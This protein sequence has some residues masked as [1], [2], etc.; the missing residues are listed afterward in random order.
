ML[1]ESIY[2]TAA[3]T[4]SV[5][6]SV[7]Y[8]LMLSYVMFQSYSLNKLTGATAQQQTDSAAIMSYVQ[9]DFATYAGAAAFSGAI[10]AGNMANWKAAVEAAKAKAQSGSEEA[11]AEAESG[12]ELIA[13]LIAF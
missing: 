9:N 4:L 7:V 13:E 10:V 2:Y 3:G 12:E 5:V 6:H 1:G 11:E 8:L